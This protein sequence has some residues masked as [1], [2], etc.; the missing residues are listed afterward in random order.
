MN[1]LEVPG[2]AGSVEEI[3]FGLRLDLAEIIV[4]HL[5]ETGKTQRQFANEMGIDEATLSRIINASEN[6][7]CRTVARVAYA[8]RVPCKLQP[9]WW[10]DAAQTLSL[11]PGGFAHHGKAKIECRIQG[12]SGG[13]SVYNVAHGTPRAG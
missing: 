5:V 12:V 9:V 2:H 1:R 8:A 6:W 13:P 3:E 4:N 11:N 7:K 10:D